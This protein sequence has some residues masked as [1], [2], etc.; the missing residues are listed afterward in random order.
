[1]T[2]FLEGGWA[3]KTGTFTICTRESLRKTNRSNELERQRMRLEALGVSLAS[4]DADELT[5]L[6]KQKPRLVD[7]FFGRSWVEPFCRPDE[8]KTLEN[9]LDTARIIDLRNRLLSLYRNLFAIHDPGF[10]PVPGLALPLGR[11][12][13]VHDV[14]EQRSIASQAIQAPRAPNERENGQKDQ[15]GA[16]GR[17]VPTAYSQRRRLPDSL[18]EGPRHILVGGPGTGKY[19]ILRFLCIDLLTPNPRL[20]A[21]A[22]TWESHLPIW[23]SFPYWTRLL[24]ERQ[25]SLEEAAHAW[26]LEVNEDS[27]APSR[28]PKRRPSAPSR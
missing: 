14:Y 6:L 25:A 9:R 22:R 24:T 16:E 11:R 4:W 18:A 21:V 17:V 19:S 8:A 20:T 7:E 12:Y 26:L 10:P 2:D 13:V 23:I 28:R 1:M 15:S 5:L 27:L 3:S